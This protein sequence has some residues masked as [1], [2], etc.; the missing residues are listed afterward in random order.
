MNR[1]GDFVIPVKISFNDINIKN[2]EL[3]ELNIVL[4]CINESENNY[5]ALGR[6]NPMTYNEIEQ[7]YIESLMN[8]LEYFCG[9]YLDNTLIGIIKGRIENK[10]E[11]ELWILSYLFFKKYRSSGNGTKILKCFEEH[12]YYNYSIKK[13]CILIMENNEQG[14]KFW[15]KNEYKIARIT[16][17]ANLNKIS[18]M[19]I[20]EK[21]IGKK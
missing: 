16:K 17:A 13:F 2:I 20:L 11:K 21:I 12:F 7:R 14:Q 3:T 5:G 18:E 10:N 15:T 8:S 6:N 4:T 1:M 9:I 19:M